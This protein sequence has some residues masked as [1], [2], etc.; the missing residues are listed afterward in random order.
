MT[1]DIEKYEG[2][3][4]KIF[5]ISYDKQER[6]EI[7]SMT[8]A[9]QVK[10]WFYKVVN[11]WFYEHLKLWSNEFSE[12]KIFWILRFFEFLD[13]LIFLNFWIFGNFEFF[14]VLNFG[15]VWILEI[16]ENFQNLEPWKCPKGALKVSWRN[17]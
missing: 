6:Y 1:I 2:F 12:F 16:F 9:T 10:L 14:E 5:C 4:W 13:F 11:L 17:T 3:V 7:R 8:A 15:I